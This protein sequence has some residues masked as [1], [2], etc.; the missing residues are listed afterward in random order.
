MCLED[1]K[2]SAVRIP[3]EGRLGGYRCAGPG[4]DLPE[5]DRMSDYHIIIEIGFAK[6][7]NPPGPTA[8]IME[9][10]PPRAKPHPTSL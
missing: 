9:L 8:A 4:S 5:P 1:A 2:K 7:H 6:L 3:G 10:V